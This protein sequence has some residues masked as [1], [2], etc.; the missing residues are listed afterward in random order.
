M[1]ASQAAKKSRVHALPELQHHPD[2]KVA[3]LEPVYS[4]SAGDDTDGYSKSHRLADAMRRSPA[5]S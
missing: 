4:P 2:V 3:A 5:T 1:R